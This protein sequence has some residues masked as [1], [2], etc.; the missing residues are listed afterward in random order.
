MANLP[1]NGA[2]DIFGVYSVRGNS[3]LGA[4]F[5]AKVMPSTANKCIQNLIRPGTRFHM[6]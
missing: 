3:F 2:T 1:A 5:A 4:A 6:C